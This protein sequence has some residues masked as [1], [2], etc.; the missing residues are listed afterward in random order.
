MDKPVELGNVEGFIPYNAVLGVDLAL[1]DGDLT[2]VVGLQSHDGRV[3]LLDDPLAV[4]PVDLEKAKRWWEEHGA[5]AVVSRSH[6]AD[7][8]GMVLAPA[9]EWPMLIL[10]PYRVV[11]EGFA[12]NFLHPSF[13]GPRRFADVRYAEVCEH[14]D[15][16]TRA[17]VVAA[18]I[19]RAERREELKHRGWLRYARRHGLA[20]RAEKLAARQPRRP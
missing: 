14:N 6:E 19:W 10:G 4:N 2:G 18:A 13:C 17:A 8:P 11:E 3:L 16:V 5:P 12:D 15:S 1:P 7:L 9:E 20:T